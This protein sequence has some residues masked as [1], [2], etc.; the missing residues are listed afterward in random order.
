MTNANAG[1]SRFLL[2]N[3]AALVSL[4]SCPN[5]DGDNKKGGQASDRAKGKGES[6][7]R[8]RPTSMRSLI[9]NIASHDISAI[10][11]EF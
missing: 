9:G 7:G 11:Q 6:G 4:L 2:G 3:G 5:D 10:H 1:R 8:E